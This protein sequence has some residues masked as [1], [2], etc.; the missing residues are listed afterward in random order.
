MFKDFQCGEQAEVE[1][2]LFENMNI[3]QNSIFV[4]PASI[5]SFQCNQKAK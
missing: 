2:E 3:Y 1:T 4:F 5:G